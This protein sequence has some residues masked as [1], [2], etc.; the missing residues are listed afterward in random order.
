[1][2]ELNVH[3]GEGLDAALARASE[4]VRRAKAGK[5]VRE[6]HVSFATWE[7]FS[8]TMTTKRFELLRHVHRNPEASIAALA[9]ALGRDYKR[10]HEDVEALTAAG[11]LDREGGGV[12]APY[13]EIRTAVAL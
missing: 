5:T 11:L 6:S 3:V 9:R 1:M 7:L 12:Q 2:A 4:A 13:D 8:S 10:V